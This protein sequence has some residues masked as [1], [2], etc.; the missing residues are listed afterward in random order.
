MSLAGALSVAVDKIWHVGTNL[1]SSPSLSQMSFS[2]NNSFSVWN[3]DSRLVW[4]TKSLA[5]HNSL[6]IFSS[7]T[8]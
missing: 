2:L 4:V 7:L 3:I 8:N 5:N 1:Y 6:P